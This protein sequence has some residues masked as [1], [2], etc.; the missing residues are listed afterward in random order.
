MDENKLLLQDVATHARKVAGKIH[1]PPQSNAMLFGMPQGSD[2]ELREIETKPLGVAEAI[3]VYNSR[4][5]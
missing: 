3:D 5:I 4:S 1:Q 2:K